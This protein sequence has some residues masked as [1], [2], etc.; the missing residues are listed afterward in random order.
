MSFILAPLMAIGAGLEVA[1]QYQQAKARKSQAEY[2]AEAARRQAEAVSAQ[3]RLE[4]Y[5]LERQKRLAGG[6]QRALYAKAGVNLYSGSPLEV[7]ADTAA[8]YDIDLATSK[9]NT[10]VGVS[11]Y[12]YESAYNRYAGRQAMKAGYL[13]MGSA[14]L[15]SG[16]NIFNAWPK[17]KK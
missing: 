6:A 7:L 4:Q 16:A 17:P 3:G 10:A 12:G 15:T 1:G 9:Y 2:N 14:L 5:K 8:Q 11:N 13:Q